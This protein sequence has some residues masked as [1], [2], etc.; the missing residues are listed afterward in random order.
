MTSFKSVVAVCIWYHVCL[1]FA[2]NVSTDLQWVSSGQCQVTKLF[3]LGTL[4]IVLKTLIISHV[5]IW[6]VSYRL[7]LHYNG[8]N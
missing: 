1:V 5:K 6:N 4:D 8:P 2:D 3:I 7:R